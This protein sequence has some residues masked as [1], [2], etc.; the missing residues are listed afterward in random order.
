MS[1]N[2]VENRSFFAGW[3]QGTGLNAAGWAAF[4]SIKPASK[5]YGKLEDHIGGTHNVSA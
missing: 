2:I 5:N 4:F 3:Q 1:R